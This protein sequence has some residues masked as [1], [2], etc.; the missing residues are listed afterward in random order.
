MEERRRHDYIPQNH[1]QFKA[2][3]QNL[4]DY[5]LARTFVQDNIWTFPDPRIHELRDVI[6]EFNR[7]F[8][9]TLGP[10][11]A[12]QNLARREAQAAAT[13]V[14]RAFVNQFLRFP[15]VTDVDRLEMGIPN[16]D[17]IRTDHTV[18]REEVDFVLEVSGQREITV[19]FWIRGADHRAKPDGY[20]GA[21]IIYDLLDAP[22]ETHDALNHHVMASR[23]PF[24]LH[25][26]ET[27][28]SKTVYVALAWQNERGIRGAWSDIKNAI[29]P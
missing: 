21:V 27:D 26:D 12:P 24:T 1:A 17:T 22:P 11:N 15:P 20:D 16:H 29:V 23:T 6:Q 4:L 9:E 28:R 25:F 3:A 19:R 7:V 2:F 5:V 18:V 13:R 14:I 10:R 8:N